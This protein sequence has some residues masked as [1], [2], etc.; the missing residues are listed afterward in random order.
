MEYMNRPAWRTSSYSGGNGRACIQVAA[1]NGII[2]VRDSKNYGRGP[3]Q[4]YT[5]A[6]WR[7]FVAGLHGARPGTDEPGRLA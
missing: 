4:R 7:A 3:V 6:A 1:R 2:L 5:P